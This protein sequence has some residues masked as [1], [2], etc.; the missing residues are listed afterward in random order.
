MEIESIQT[1]ADYDTALRA[2]EKYFDRL[3]CKGTP[4]AARFD[5]LATAI[6][7]YEREHWPIDPVS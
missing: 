6:K 7:A 5:A 1:E 4:E 2:I 3:P